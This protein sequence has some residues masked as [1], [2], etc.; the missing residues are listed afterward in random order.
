MYLVS[1]ALSALNMIGI[2]VKALLGNTWHTY[3][4][5]AKTVA[6]AL[7]SKD[8]K[9]WIDAVKSELNSLNTR[10]VFDITD[11]PKGRKLIHAKMVFN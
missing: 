6:E 8:S 4:T 5:I 11:L 3:E 10:N 1:S 7:S 9:N 2:I